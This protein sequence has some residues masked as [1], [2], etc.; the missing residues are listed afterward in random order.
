[1]F[2]ST[3]TENA[4]V[5]FDDLPPE[6]I[7]SYDD[8]KN[9]FLE[10]YLQ[11]KKCIKD[12]IEIHNIKQREGES[13]EDFVKR[14]KL[15]SRDVKG[16][17]ECMRI[18]G[19]VHGITNPE[20]I[21]RL[22]DKILK[23][24]DEMIRV[25][26]SFLRGRKDKAL[27]ILMVRPWER[28]AR[29]RITQSFS[30]NPE[31][32]FPPLGEDEGTEATTP[33]VRFSGEIIWPIGQIQLLVKI[34]DEEHS[35]SA[36][37]N[38][39]V[40]R[41]SS[42]YNGIIGR[43][44]VKKLQAVPSTAHGMLKI[45]VEGGVIT[46]K[47][48]KLVPL[49]CAVVF[50]PEGAP[51]ATK[52]IIE[53]RIKVVINQKYPKQTV[54]IGSTLTEEGRNKLYG[55]LQRNLDIFAWKPADMTSVP[56]HIAE[57]R[58]NV[59]EG[60]SSHDDSWRMCVD[61]KDLNKACPKD[62]YPL[63]E[64]DWKVESLCGF[65]FKC[66]LDAYKG[67]HQI[68]MAKEDEEK[69]AFITSQGI[70]CYTKMPFG[71]RNAGATYQRLVDKAFHKQIGR[72]LEVYVDDLVI[73][74]RTEDEIVR[75]IE[76]TFKTLREINMKLNPKKCTFG[77]EEG[78]F[79]GYKVNSKGLK[80]CPDKVDAV[81]SLPSPKCLKDVQKLNGKLA[82]LNRFLAKSA[83]KSLPF[84]K[85][86]K[87]C[88]KKSDF[89]WTTEA[90]EAFKQMKQLIAELPMLTAP[91]EKEELI[92]YL[93]AAK[94]TVSAVLMTEREAK[95]MPIYFV[96][97]ALR[98]PELNYTSMEKLVLALVHA[99]KRLK[100]YFQAHP[101]IV[102]TDQPIQQI[103]SR[104]EVAGRLQKWSI[105]LG[106]YA[107]H[108]RPRVSVKGQ[109]LADFIVE[110][111]EEDS[112]DTPMEE[113]EELPEPW[114]LFTDGSSCTDGSGAGL[115]LT[116]PEGMEFTYALRFR[117]DA[118][119]N[120]AEYE[121]LI[122]GLRIAEQ[123]GVKNLQAI[124][125]LRLVANQVNGTYHAK[126]ADMIRYLE[127]IKSL[128]GSFKAFTITQIPRSENKK[129]DALSKIASTSF[130][131]L[132]KT[133]EPTYRRKARAIRRKSWRF[134]V[135][136]GILYKKSFL[137]PWLRCVGPL[138][139]N[140]VLREIHKG[141]CSMHAG[142][143][144]VVAKV[145]R[146]G[147]Y[148]PTMHKDARMLIRACQDC[149]IHKPIPRNPQ[150]KLTPITSPWPFY[151][152]GID[153]AGPFPKGLGKVKFLIVAMN[154]FTKGIKAKPVATITGNQI[155]KFVW[156]NIVCRFGLPGEIISDNG[157]QFRDDPFKDLCEKLCINQHFA[158]VKH[159]QTN[160]LVE[161]ANRSLGEGIKAR[162]EARSKNWN[163]ELHH[164]AM[165]YR[166]M[167]KI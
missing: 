86:L 15:E 34:G 102:I 81:L 122:A 162:M 108:Y 64:I 58:L 18:S 49:K 6:S 160:G 166:I 107:I 14:Y 146:T 153:I 3:L 52:P 134:A 50:G 74:S 87:K 93:A 142:T 165:A 57:H 44:G 19:F 167:K 110:R 119:N 117:F 24:V 66:F 150:Q 29:Q 7:D 51:S 55:L 80:V 27:A 54:M 156:D 159:P 2:N 101:I 77:V 4:R 75:D 139:A 109:I 157:K 123:M 84:F 120:E 132:R 53:E 16:A 121:A 76:E 5:W 161:R 70:F 98:G 145:L 32:F 125:D 8:L 46:L 83:E 41:S 45:L 42:P 127:K 103:L 25:T 89:H 38:F 133:T 43:P 63:P 137:G 65:P 95:Q 149:Q 9:V 13:T 158:S 31:I 100:R 164:F 28:V 11:Q 92:V 73:K 91:M 79:L 140:Y 68:Q 35:V 138:Q 17:P 148:W 56:R 67:Y 104:P 62:G 1:M 144:T 151:K 106:E 94:E 12:P 21:K 130:A 131:H 126:E 154:Y 10:N 163:E 116:N 113:E 97:R 47:S 36:W 61:F 136:N 26:T 118:T 96:S 143:R 105:E 30:P 124:L 155:K 112:P 115:I 48:S 78:M 39:M 72:N 128:T 99:S 135:I 33:L 85:T 111:P 129:A 20:L 90:E 82:S 147:Y 60:C 23:T 114:I 71:L 152:W 22:Y 40:V 59:R 37:I 88:T 69:T 141:S